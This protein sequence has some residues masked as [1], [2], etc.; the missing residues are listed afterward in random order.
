MSSRAFSDII[1]LRW[2]SFSATYQHNQIS[3]WY[4]SEIDR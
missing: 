4:Y 3:V 2:S 1:H